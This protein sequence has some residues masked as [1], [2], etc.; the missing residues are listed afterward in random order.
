MKIKDGT[1]ITKGMIFAGCSFTWGQGL[2]YYSNLPTLIENS[3]Y[4]YEPEF[5]TLAHHKFKNKVRWPKLVADHLDSFE[6]VHP[7]NGGSNQQILNYWKHCLNWKPENQ[8][9]PAF[10]PNEFDIVEKI[11][12]KEI[13]HF[14]LQLTQFMRDKVEFS[15]DGQHVNIELQAAWDEHRPYK[16]LFEKWFL[17][18]PYKNLGEYHDL[19]YSATI[20]KIKSFF[21]ECEYNGVKCFL[22][23]WPYEWVE[24]I[25]KDPWLK[26][27]FIDFHYKEK[28]YTSI[29][30]L[31][32]HNPETVIISDHEYFDEPPIDTHP[33]LLCQKIIADNVIRVLEEKRNG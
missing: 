13:S 1:K 15:V 6:I 18:Q 2:Q 8:S 27:R 3:P 14:V 30:M 32:R 28:I 19:I 4:G 31:H 17:N 33:N 22:M 16:K 21:Q 24:Y 12:Y 10:R 20:R 9:V 26:E 7:K 23:C 11:N 25:N 29:E 5:W